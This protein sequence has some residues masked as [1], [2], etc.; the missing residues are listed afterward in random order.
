[1]KKEHWFNIYFMPGFIFQSLVIGGGYATGRELVE[2]FLSLGPLTGL[3][4][5]AVTTV[6]WSLVAAVSFEFARSAASYDYRSFFRELLGPGWFLFEL[7]YLILMLLVLAIIAAASGDMMAHSFGGSP[8]V[9]TLALMGSIGILTFYGSNVIE[10]VL[11]LWS[12]VLYGAYIIFLVWGVSLFGDHVSRA[13]SHSQLQ[14]GWVVA[15]VRYAGYNLAVI[16]AVLFCVRHIQKRRQALV[17]G[18][19]AGVLAIVPGVLFYVVMTGFYPDIVRETVPVSTILATYHAR[20]FELLFQVVIFGTFIETG[21][22]ML[23]AINERV[24]HKL[25]E[26]GRSMPAFLRPALAIG[27]LIFAIVVGNQLGL[28]R[29]IAKGYG[30]LTWAFVL[31][32][33]IPVLT[34]GLAKIMRETPEQARGEEA[35]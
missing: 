31:I 3:L 4:A 22:G 15:G 28:V 12:F 16:P 30:I 14:S 19:I 1:M 7:A 5:M 23:H 24:V 6:V 20:W 34:L 27:A 21:T 32:F 29:L 13:F 2:F 25:V 35:A 17:S 18:G 8:L 9:G 10:T 11:S 26:Q 33:V